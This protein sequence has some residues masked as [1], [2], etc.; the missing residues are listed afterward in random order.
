LVEFIEA[1]F[2]CRTGFSPYTVDSEEIM[3]DSIL[4][5]Y[6]KIK[7]MPSSAIDANTLDQLAEEING[8]WLRTN[9][10]DIRKSEAMC[11]YLVSLADKS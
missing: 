7:Q 1:V 2:G 8:I 4:N 11:E 3:P 10:D 9:K 5:F 6:N